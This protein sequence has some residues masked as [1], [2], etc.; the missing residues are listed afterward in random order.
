MLVVSAKLDPGLSTW[1][2]DTNIDN[3]LDKHD[4]AAEITEERTEL[5]R[6]ATIRNVEMSQAGLGTLHDQGVNG[7]KLLSTTIQSNQ[8]WEWS[9]RYVYYLSVSMEI[10]TSLCNRKIDLIAC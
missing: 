7:S 2:I 4:E 8:V 9:T 3:K 10:V 1:H 6:T 5:P